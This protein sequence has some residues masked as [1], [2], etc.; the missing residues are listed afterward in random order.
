ME[1]LEVIRHVRWTTRCTN[2][3]RLLYDYHDDCS[4]A[5]RQ[6]RLP[7][8]RTAYMRILYMNIYIR[9]HEYTYIKY[10]TLCL[11]EFLAL[12]V[13]LYIIYTH[14]SQ[15]DSYMNTHNQAQ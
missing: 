15:V 13:Y 12:Y 3:R 14:I 10:A 1:L 6:M 4:P 11:F 9:I 5:A 2:W 7:A 8:I